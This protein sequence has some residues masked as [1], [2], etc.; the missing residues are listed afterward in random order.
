MLWRFERVQNPFAHA[1]S[2]NES[3]GN[4][5][6]WVKTVEPDLRREWESYKPMVRKAYNG[7][8]KAVAESLMFYLL[9]QWRKSEPELALSFVGYM[10]DAANGAEA[11]LKPMFFFRQYAME[12]KAA[13]DSGT[14]GY[15]GR[16]AD[17]KELIYKAAIYTWDCLL[18]GKKFNTY[19]GFKSGLGQFTA[20]VYSLDSDAA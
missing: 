9:Y 13:N 19:N 6:N 12:I 15:K 16:H 3:D 17:V 7:C 20:K 11:P 14:L 10:A 5:Y 4:I 2:F 1:G 18:S 8:K